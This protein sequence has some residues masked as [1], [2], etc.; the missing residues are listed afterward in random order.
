MKYLMLLS[1]I[2]SISKFFLFTGPD[3]EVP[4][5][6]HSMIT[7]GLGQ[8]IIGG[9]SETGQFQNN[10][11]L[12]KKYLE[13]TH[14][15]FSPESVSQTSFGKLT[16]LKRASKQKKIILIKGILIELNIPKTP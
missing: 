16:I 14:I 4:L 10:K 9:E 8:A 11:K 2:K 13:A 7:L 15:P 1:S 3:L 6:G 12:N 5:S